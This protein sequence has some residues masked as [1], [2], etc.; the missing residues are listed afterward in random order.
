MEGA[1]TIR[2]D[3]GD[4]EAL[5]LPDY[6]AKFLTDEYESRFVEPELGIEILAL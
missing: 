5:P 2:L 6:A 4:F 1:G 3:A